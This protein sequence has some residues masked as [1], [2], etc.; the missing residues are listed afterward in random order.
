VN[1]LITTLTALVGIKKRVYPHL[2]RHPFGTYCL[3]RGMNP[4]QV[5]EIMGDSSLAM[6]TNVYAHL[7]PQDAQ[8]AMTKALLEYDDSRR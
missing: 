8:V 4:I 2:L 7:Y 5:A 6:M 1:Q 3:R